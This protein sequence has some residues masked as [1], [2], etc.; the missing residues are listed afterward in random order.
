MFFNKK[1][2]ILK[3]MH[4]VADQQGIIKRFLKESENWG[5]HLEHCKAAIKKDLSGRGRG[6]CAVLGSGWLLDIPIDALLEHFEKVYL[7][8][9]IHPTQV[10]HKYAHNP[11]VVFVELDITGSVITQMF[12]AVQYYKSTK[13]VK[14][15][16]TY[17]FEGF[18]YPEEFD[19][20]I[21]ANIISQLA[22][23]LVEY[24]TPY[25]L[26]SDEELALLSRKVEESHLQ[27]LPVGKTFLITDYE[28]LVY[29]KDNILEKQRPLLQVSFNSL[30]V[31]E[32]WQWKFD[33]DDYYKDKNVVYNV[34]ALQ[35]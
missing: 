8:D 10:K 1:Y 28:E 35:K 34:I 13:Y 14:N 29:S 33:R 22:T 18:Q 11:K 23:L 5:S 16:D 26:Y 17:Q 19:F 12:E 7:F 20:V 3:K 21:S 6:K 30:P 9:I 32:S 24:I 31:A 15:I 2:R 27:S 25:G 4:Y